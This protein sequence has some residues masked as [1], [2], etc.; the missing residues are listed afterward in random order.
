MLYRIIVF[1]L[2]IQVIKPNNKIWF[3]NMLNTENY[4]IMLTQDKEGILLFATSGGVIEYDGYNKKIIT[5]GEDS[6]SSNLVPS[7]FVDSEGLI[8]IVTGKGLNLYDKKTAKFQ[9]FI[10][11]ETNKFSISSND[12]NW[13]PKLIAEDKEGYIWIGTKFGLNRYDKKENKF[14]NYSNSDIFNSIVDHNIWTV[15]VDKNDNVWFG[16]ENGGLNCYDKKHNRVIVYNTNDKNTK[17]YIGKGI[18]YSILEDKIGN[19]WVG[20][21]E[22]GLTKI[23]RE[24]VVERRYEHSE[25]IDS[26][27]SNEVFSL[28][29]DSNGLIWIGRNYSSSFGI[30]IFNPDLE[31]FICFTEKDGVGLSG[32]NYM[33]AFEDESGTIWLPNNLGEIDK[34]DFK[35]PN[36]IKNENLIDDITPLTIYQSDSIWFGTA[37]KGLVK[38]NNGEY[39]FFSKDANKKSGL[40]TNY[41]FSILEEDENELWLSTD[42]GKI[43]LFDIDKE[44]VVK[45]FQNPVVKSSAR[46]MIKDKLNNDLLWFGT[47]GNGIFKFN[48]KTGKFTQYKNEKENKN[49]LS[50][51]IV[52][53]LYQD[54]F[55]EIWIPTYGG[56]LNKFNRETDDF[57]IYQKNIGKDSISGNIIWDCYLDSKGRFWITS[58][59]G[60][61]SQFLKET[62]KFKIIHWSMDFTQDLYGR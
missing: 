6:I 3:S 53:N 27:V 47:E 23:N 34:Y 61:L 46:G 36:F 59:D 25:K 54:K 4:N 20:T 14:L 17:N 51:N 44:I 15:I 39:K 38:Y 41:V 12:Y 60:G 30:E 22:G 10:H 42:D 52:Q 45:E 24:L 2:I 8:W 32:N 43:L 26:I 5:S 62:G 18:V 57:T 35:L 33:S 29:Q 21:S 13:A 55:G 48:K 1:F 50:N 11:D 37:N 40:L 16:T 31:K 7:I 58:E 56:G 9:Y 28:M 19:I 49:S